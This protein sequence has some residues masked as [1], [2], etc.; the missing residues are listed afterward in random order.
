MRMLGNMPKMQ[1]MQN[2]RVPKYA[3][4]KLPNQTKHRQP[5][6]PNQTYQQRP[7]PTQIIRVH[8]NGV[9][10][11]DALFWSHL[12][13]DFYS[14]IHDFIIFH[15][16]LP[17]LGKILAAEASA[18]QIKPIKLN[19]PIQTNMDLFYWFLVFVII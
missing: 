18:Y 4:P 15:N 7:Q 17:Y 11:I 8:S 10:Y 9:Y 3:K 13:S 6:S 5:N 14:D 2:A 1:N 19:L 16:L 12:E